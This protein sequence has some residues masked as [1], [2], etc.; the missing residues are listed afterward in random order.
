M[1]F[2]EVN[3]VRLYYE[4]HGDRGEPM[5]FVHGYTGDVTD[6]R[7][8][9]PEFSTTH[10]LL[11]FDHRGHGRSEAPRDRSLYTIDHMRGDTE[12]LIE[13]AAFERYHLIGHSMGGAVSQELALRHGDRIISL[14]LEDTGP[15]MSLAP[16]SPYARWSQARTR[17]ADEQGMAAVADFPGL[18]APLP[19]QTDERKEEEQRRLAEMSV[20]GFIGAQHGLREWAGIRE[21]IAGITQ[22]TLVICGEMDAG[23]RRAADWLAEHLPHASLEI[24]PQAG[25]SP[26]YERPDLFNAAVRRHVEKHSPGTTK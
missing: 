21:R 11:I 16:D 4:L 18:T 13:L 5:V 12:A 6:W 14:V 23:L 8:Q 10:R 2:A 17:M 1:P 25:H 20:D 7:H 24:I 19:F 9:L 3:G 26:Q 15:R 22:P